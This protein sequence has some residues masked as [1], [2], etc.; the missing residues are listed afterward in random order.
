MR[1]GGKKNKA[2]DKFSPREQDVEGEKKGRKES[3][4][5]FLLPDI[6]STAVKERLLFLFDLLAVSSK[7]PTGLLSLR[8]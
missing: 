7:V 6:A 5:F 3:F 2:N 1:G 4:S 8:A